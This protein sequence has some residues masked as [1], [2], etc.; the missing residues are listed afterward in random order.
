MVDLVE[1]DSDGAGVT[2]ALTNWIKMVGAVGAELKSVIS[3]RWAVIFYRGNCL[4]RGRNRVD[5]GLIMLKLAPFGPD[6]FLLYKLLFINCLIYLHGRSSHALDELPSNHLGN[7]TDTM[8]Q[9]G[10]I[11]QIFFKR[12]FCKIFIKC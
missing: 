10:W 8:L 12:I 6:P 2:R 7:Y 11:G 1:P 3:T 4:G 5:V 9:F